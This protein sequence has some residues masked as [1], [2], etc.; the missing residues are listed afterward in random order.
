MEK[1]TV[2]FVVACISQQHILVLGLVPANVWLI[3]DRP[4]LICIALCTLFRV[5]HILHDRDWKSS[6][7]EVDLVNCC[8]K[9]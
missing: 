4:S 1:G 5:V 9:Y 7:I 3:Q 6:H 8:H 2:C